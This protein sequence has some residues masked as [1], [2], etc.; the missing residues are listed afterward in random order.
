MDIEIKKDHKHGVNSFKKGENYIVSSVLGR[1]LVDKG[2]AID[3]RGE[4]SKKESKIIKESSDKS[5]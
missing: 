1:E 5:E 4:Y 3:L 2:F